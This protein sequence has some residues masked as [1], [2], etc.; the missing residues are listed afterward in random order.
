MAPQFET[1][2]SLFFFVF[3]NFVATT[4]HYGL[5]KLSVPLKCL[6]SK[7]FSSFLSRLVP[8]SR[9]QRGW[10]LAGGY[11]NSSLAWRWDS[12]TEVEAEMRFTHW[13]PLNSHNNLTE[14]CLALVDDKALHWLSLPCQG[15]EDASMVLQPLCEKRLDR[16]AIKVEKL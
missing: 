2:K 6:P 3:F 4:G 10:W 12:D 16:E 13:H 5:V 7:L 14:H 11:D 1:K 15:R 8:I 9:R